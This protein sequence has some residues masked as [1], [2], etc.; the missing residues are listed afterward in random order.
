MTKSSTL[1]KVRAAP[2]KALLALQLHAHLQRSK[3]SELLAASC[4]FQLS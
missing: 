1:K 4:S 2:N 3:Q